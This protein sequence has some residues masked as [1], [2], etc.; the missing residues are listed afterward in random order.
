MS[1]Q[2][3][4]RKSQNIESDLISIFIYLLYAFMSYDLEM[5]YDFINP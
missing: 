1:S 5:K 4:Q 2:N 3:E